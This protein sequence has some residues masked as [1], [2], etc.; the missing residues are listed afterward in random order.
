MTKEPIAPL[1][2]PICEAVILVLD[3]SITRSPG[4]VARRR[5]ATALRVVLDRSV[6]GWHVRHAPGSDLPEYDITPPSGETLAVDDGWNLSYTLAEL[7]DVAHAE[8]AFAVIQDAKPV[9]TPEPAPD[10]HEAGPLAAPS[11]ENCMDDNPPAAVDPNDIDWS[12]RLVDAPCAWQLD[13]PPPEAGFPPGQRRGKGIR[14]GHPD[15][16]YLDHPDYFAEPPGQPIRVMRSLERDFVDND[17]VAEDPDGGHGLNTGATIMS[18][19]ATG[20]VVGIAPEA[21]IVPLRVPNRASAATSPLPSSSTAVSAIC[22]MPS[23]TRP[24]RPAVT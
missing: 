14:V 23:A 9:I 21:E 18:S 19:E 3:E 17:K 11:Y 10:T 13:P 20:F 16:G 1:S 4:R 7:P 6:R 8:P 24:M 12:P 5:L 22:A 15:S 2:E